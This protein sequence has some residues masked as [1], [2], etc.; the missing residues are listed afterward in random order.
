MFLFRFEKL[1]DDTFVCSLNSHKDCLSLALW[2]KKSKETGYVSVSDS[3]GWFY[4]P[5]WETVSNKMQCLAHELVGLN[6]VK[7]T[8][9]GDDDY[10]RLIGRGT[11]DKIELTPTS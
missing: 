6:I 5:F 2:L 10:E 4:N 1:N 8:I 11:V 3:Y 7:G 9:K